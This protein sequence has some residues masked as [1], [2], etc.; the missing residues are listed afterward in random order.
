[1][2]KDKGVDKPFNR[3][4]IPNVLVDLGRILRVVRA[5]RKNGPYHLTPLGKYVAKS[6][7]LENFTFYR[8][9]NEF[10]YF[11]L[12]ILDFLETKPKSLVIITETNRTDYLTEFIEK[13]LE[14]LGNDNKTE[15][16]VKVNNFDA[17]V[18]SS[19]YYL[20]RTK[21]LMS[22][23]YDPLNVLEL[24]AQLVNLF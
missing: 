1:M 13:N 19:R 18:T 11:E 23:S 6:I 20:S 22:L 5:E 16:D 15:F 10:K 4:V 24:N 9:S 8:L 2:E 12:A 3:H 17:V 21:A 7:N 14:I